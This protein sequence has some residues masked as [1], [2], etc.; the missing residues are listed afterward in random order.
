MWPFFEKCPINYPKAINLCICALFLMLDASENSTLAEVP[1]DP[2]LCNGQ[3]I[4][5]K[6][7]IPLLGFSHTCMHN[8]SNEI[9]NS[10]FFS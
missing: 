9:S 8:E 4:T 3:P 7:L 10:T 6:V 5:N 1:A 2:S